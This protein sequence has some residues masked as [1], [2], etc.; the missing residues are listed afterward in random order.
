MRTVPTFL[1]VAS[2]A[3]ITGLTSCGTSTETPTETAD[4]SASASAAPADTAE[5][6]ITD[7]AQARKSTHLT[8][9][10]AKIQNG[11]TT[12]RDII[13]KLGMFYTKGTNAAGQATGTW[14]YKPSESTGKA[15][16]PGSAF[17]PGAV[18]TYYQS[19]TAVFGPNDVVISHSFLE[20]T[21]EKTG[22]GFSY[23]S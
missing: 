14:T 10:A 15:W 9:A 11:V 1:V 17:I 18:I 6:D 19:V 12:R 13:G 3:A 16:I 20:S 5:G 8:K 7:P 22:L 23:G 4:T 2:V 21:K